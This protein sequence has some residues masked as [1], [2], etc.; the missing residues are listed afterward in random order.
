MS[1]AEIL[2]EL[3]NLNA[4]DLR[5]IYE[6]ILQLEEQ[7]LLSGKAIPTDEEKALLDAE[8]QEYHRDPNAGSSWEDVKSRLQQ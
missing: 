5:E 8:L 3:P 4:R 2:Q 7:H 6:R 1:K